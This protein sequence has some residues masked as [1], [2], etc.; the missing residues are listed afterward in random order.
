MAV[1]LPL[2][3]ARSLCAPFPSTVSTHPGP[4]GCFQKAAPH[5][6]SAYSALI[7]LLA[8]FPCFAL[9]ATPPFLAPPLSPALSNQNACRTKRNEDLFLLSLFP[10]HCLSFLQPAFLTSPVLQRHFG[11]P[12]PHPFSRARLGPAVTST[13]LRPSKELSVPFTNTRLK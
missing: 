7:Q 3:Q 11:S 6:C 12:S 9:F 8:A 1:A 2:C 5:L 10:F 13:R 4:H